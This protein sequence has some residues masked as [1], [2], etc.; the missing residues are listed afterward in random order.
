M[1]LDVFPSY[2]DKIMV[3]ALCRY[4][5]DTRLSINILVENYLEKLLYEKGYLT[6]ELDDE[7]QPLLVEKEVKRN[8]HF[9]T[10]KQHNRIRL[11]YKNL[12]FS[13]HNPDNIEEIK[14]KLLKYS[15]E[16]LKELS[17]NCWDGSIKGYKSFLYSK[18]DINESKK[19]LD[20]TESENK[21]MYIFKN[22]DKY[23]VQKT[24]SRSGSNVKLGFGTYT[25]WE[26]A[27][28]VKEF[29]RS[30]NWDSKYSTNETGLKGKKYIQWLYNEMEKEQK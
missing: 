22:K 7:N 17:V 24:I 26:E 23:Q 8:N 30:K 4:E 1:I 5:R 25:T 13:S 29:I 21:D 15:D 28:E 2:K 20:I 27:Y 3:D 19:K 6:V 10:K 18:L 16:K 14:N 9:S 11:F 12:D